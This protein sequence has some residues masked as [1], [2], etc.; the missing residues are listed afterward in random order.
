MPCRPPVRRPG[1]PTFPAR[2][3]AVEYGGRTSRY[4]EEGR[5]AVRDSPPSA[6][7]VFA[8]LPEP[9][10]DDD[11]LRASIRAMRAADGLLLGVLDD[12][13]TGSQAVHGVQ[14]VTVLE[15][16]A[17]QA[18]LAGPAATCFVL[19]NTRSMEEPAAAEINVLAARGLLSV[20]GRRGAR[21]QLLSRSDS[22]LRGHVMA[23]VTAL[24]SVRRET[25]R[26]GYD[27]VL[28]VPAFLE[29]GRLTAG[30][31]HWSRW[32]RPSSRRMPRSATAHRTC[33]TSWRRRA[34]ARS[35][36]AT[37]AA[38]AWPTSGS[39]ARSESASCWPGCGTAAG[40]W[41][42]PPNTP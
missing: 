19:T 39:A 20:A 16:A 35:G 9:R 28:F 29:A 17:Y 22:T 33:V 41:S 37:S 14:V 10:P 31:I 40:P 11:G 12:D 21:L 30:D 2:P 32:A 8:G 24:D 4:P 26:R 18:A 15:E 42:T 3:W 1:A 5:R 34:A 25:A 38:S 23:E 6:T 7:E 13:P 36:G 27:G